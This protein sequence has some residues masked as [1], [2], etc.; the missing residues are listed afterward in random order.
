M[1]IEQDPS[2][3]TPSVGFSQPPPATPLPEED[4]VIDSRPVPFSKVLLRLSRVQT[5]FTCPACIKLAR[6]LFSCVAMLFIWYALSLTCLPRGVCEQLSVELE[7]LV[8]ASVSAYFDRDLEQPH[9]KQSLD[10][11]VFFSPV[12]IKNSECTLSPWPSINICKVYSVSAI[13]SK[14]KLQKLSTV[15]GS[16]TR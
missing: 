13:T 6:S 16:L 9:S 5:C 2:N 15:L 7:C 10:E 12:L 1:G 14:L 3:F 8:R 4:Q 11:G